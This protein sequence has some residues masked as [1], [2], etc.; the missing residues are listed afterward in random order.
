MSSFCSPPDHQDE[1]DRLE[2]A[3]DGVRGILKEAEAI[4][5][6]LEHAE[7]LLFFADHLVAHDALDPNSLVSFDLPISFFHN[8][9]YASS[10][11]SVPT[12]FPGVVSISAAVGTSGDSASGSPTGLNM[13]LAASGL[14]S[15]GACLVTSTTAA[16][17]LGTS[18]ASGTGVPPGR[19][20]VDLRAKLRHPDTRMVNYD[21]LYIEVRRNNKIVQQGTV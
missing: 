14:A 7:K 3:R 11:L 1:V 12:N 21:K 17:S 5:T 2:V 8:H 6:R 18:A 15:P 13:S 9:P 10:T 19:V 4:M 16:N 20:R